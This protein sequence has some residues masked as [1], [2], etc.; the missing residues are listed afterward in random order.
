[1]SNQ[2]ARTYEE[3][4]KRTLITQGQFAVSA[5][6]NEVITTLLGS[7]VSCCIWDEVAGVGGMNHML[8]GGVE[9]RNFSG[10]DISGTAD[11][12]LLINGLLKLGA[13]RSHL[14]AKV[15]GGAQLLAARTQIGSKNVEFALS[16][17]ETENIPCLNTSTGGDSARSIR[18]WPVTGR[19]NMK[20]ASQEQEAVRPP[21]PPKEQVGNGLELF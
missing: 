9:M 3:T 17:L 12:E 15:F 5:N 4:G 16:Y 8:L 10:C 6:E 7:C 20:L 21:E 14:K 11:M 2:L 19:V 18:F 1:M 13:N